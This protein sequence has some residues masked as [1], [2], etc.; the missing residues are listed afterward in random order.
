MTAGLENAFPD[1]QMDRQVLARLVRELTGAGL[2]HANGAG[3]WRLTD[4]GHH[5]LETGSLAVPAEERR[6]FCF[7]DNAALHRPP[8]F[9][10]LRQP[11]RP[12]PPAPDIKD[13]FF[14][15]ANLEACIRQ[16]VDWKARYHFP[17][18]VEALLPPRPDEPPEENSRRVILDS[19]AQMAF[20]FIRTTTSAMLGFRVRTEGWVLEPEPVLALGEGWEEVLPDLAAEPPPE[21]WRQAWRAWSHPRSLPSAEVDACRL[22]HSDHRLL[23]RA[24]QRLIERLRAARS[25]AIKQEA[26][27]LA[28]VGR[29]RTAAQL[30][31][32]PL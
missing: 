3:A 13:C 9:L 4:A 20:V 29:T 1:L 23:V 12:I 7:V 18:E 24:P 28:G 21:A 26:W 16:T 27:L 22:E 17:A 32:L 25:D 15:I 30:E 14:D 5:A 11:P 31:L 8:H 19:P 2:L 10:P 6:T